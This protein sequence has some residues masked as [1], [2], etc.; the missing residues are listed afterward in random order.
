MPLVY[1]KRHFPLKSTIV[2]AIWTDYDNTVVQL[3]EAVGLEDAAWWSLDEK[4]ILLDPEMKI[5]DMHK[6]LLGDGRSKETPY[7]AKFRV[8]G[9]FLDVFLFITSTVPQAALKWM[10]VRREPKPEQSDAE[11]RV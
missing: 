3:E 2:E 9:V 7:E 1:V 4:W 8:G 6:L 10:G 5:A 11:K